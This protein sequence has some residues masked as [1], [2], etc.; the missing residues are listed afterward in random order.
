MVTATCGARVAD[1]LHDWVGFSR[2]TLIHFG[3][4]KVNVCHRPFEVKPSITLLMSTV[5]ANR[6]EKIKHLHREMTMQSSTRYETLETMLW[7]T[8]WSIEWQLRGMYCSN[9]K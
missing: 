3:P 6:T 4:W 1:H 5:M 8:K 2:V 7:R 9:R